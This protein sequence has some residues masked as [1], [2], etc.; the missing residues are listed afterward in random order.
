MQLTRNSRWLQVVALCFAIDHFAPSHEARNLLAV[1][2]LG[3]KLAHNSTSKL[4]D[5]R[6][7][8]FGTS[9]TYGS[10]L[11]LERKEKAFPYLLSTNA[12]NLAIR[13]AG[14]Q[15]PALCTYSMLGEEQYDVILLEYNMKADENLLRLSQRLRDR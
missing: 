5:L 8:A 13:A 14:P 11:G 7:V 6:L 4:D 12:S 1:D 10:G 2:Y 9:R 15:Y 3:S